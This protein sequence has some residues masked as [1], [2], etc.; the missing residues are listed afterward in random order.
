VK[1]ILLALTLL[2]IMPLCVFARWRGSIGVGFG[3]PVYAGYYYPYYY[4]YAYPYYPYGYPYGYGYDYY[5]GYYNGYPYY[6]TPLYNG[7]V[8]I[9]YFEGGRW[10][11]HRMN[12]ESWRREG[13]REGWRGM[14]AGAHAGRR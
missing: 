9:V 10:N 12:G 1:K 13:W 3:V 8:D 14:R 6:A 5:D 7:W 11:H 2:A 4:P